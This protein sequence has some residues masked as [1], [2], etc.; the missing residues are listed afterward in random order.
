LRFSKKRKKKKKGGLKIE[1]SLTK[2]G[3]GWGVV[4]DPK[5][6]PHVGEEL[7]KRTHFKM[8]GRPYNHRRG[9][10]RCRTLHLRYLWPSSA[11]QGANL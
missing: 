11:T 7:V 4:G 1:N 6:F 10:P 8:R 3:W 9:P 2:G 5:A